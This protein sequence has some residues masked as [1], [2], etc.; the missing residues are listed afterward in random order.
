MPRLTTAGTRARIPWASS[1]GPG[2]T[3]VGARRVMPGC[4]MASIYET[5]IVIA[6]DVLHEDHLSCSL[7]SLF[8]LGPLMMFLGG[9]ESSVDRGME[10]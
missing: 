5:E 3:D 10:L 1:T 4:P 2:G 6:A 9:F 7:D 8:G